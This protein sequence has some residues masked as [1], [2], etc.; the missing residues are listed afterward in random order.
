[1]NTSIGSGWR[2]WPRAAAVRVDEEA[3]HVRLLDGRELAV[4]INWFGFLERR[5]D[6]ELRDVTIIEG[7]RGLWW[8]SIDEGVSVPSLLGLPE[9]P[10]QARTL[11]AETRE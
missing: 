5:T 1:M 3:V 2:D 11:D 6:T 4:P 10:D 9:V 7:G 8:E